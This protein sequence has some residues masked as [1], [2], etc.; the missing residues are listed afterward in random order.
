MS[1]TGDWE[2]AILWNFLFGSQVEY[3][4]FQGVYVLLNLCSLKSSSLAAH[5][6][7]SFLISSGLGFHSCEKEIK[8]ENLF[9]LTLSSL[10][11]SATMK[12]GPAIGSSAFF[13]LTGTFYVYSHST[14]T[15]LQLVSG[16]RKG[17]YTP[18]HTGAV[19][20]SGYPQLPEGPHLAQAHCFHN[21]YIILICLYRT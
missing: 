1:I 13:A 20:G 8:R 19:L 16:Y 3:C 15:L 10:C 4:R 18:S 2:M 14:L 12:E 9:S 5:L 17:L 7:F 21:N 6:W 11:D